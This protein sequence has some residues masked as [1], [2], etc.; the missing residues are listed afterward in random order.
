[1]ESQT[2]V[3]CT[4]AGCY[5]DDADSV[6]HAAP[7]FQWHYKLKFFQQKLQIF[8]TCDKYFFLTSFNSV[9]GVNWR[10]RLRN[11]INLINNRSY[12]EHRVKTSKMSMSP[13]IKRDHMASVIRQ[14]IQICSSGLLG[15]LFKTL[16]RWTICPRCINPAT[17]GLVL[18]FV[19]FT[20]VNM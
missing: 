2:G 17:I 14:V 1:M 11:T 10:L 19:N 15:L 3:F 16:C 5:L 9:F 13:V 7:N 12:E 18:I 4:L 20:V 8:L 6:C